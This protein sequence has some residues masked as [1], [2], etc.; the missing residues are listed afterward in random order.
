MEHIWL[1]E[2]AVMKE[3]LRGLLFQTTTVASVTILLTPN[4][5]CSIFTHYSDPIALDSSYMTHLLRSQSA[6]TVEFPLLDYFSHDYSALLW[7]YSFLLTLL[8]DRLGLCAR[9]I[10]I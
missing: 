2:R 6:L 4:H 7:T 10:S 9:P 3:Q 8:T 1:K 5:D